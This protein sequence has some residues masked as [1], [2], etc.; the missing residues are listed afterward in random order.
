[1]SKLGMLAICSVALAVSGAAFAKP[2]TVA[3]RAET[4][5]ALDFE[6]IAD[7]DEQGRIRAAK[8][9]NERDAVR[10]TEKSLAPRSMEA[11]FEYVVPGSEKAAFAFTVH[12]HTLALTLFLL[13]GQ[14]KVK[15]MHR[16]QCWSDATRKF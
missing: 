4:S 2:V 8:A 13:D 15:T 12:R 1:M 14:G 10:L 6:F 9:T 16:G 5:P 7:V 11:T 3:C